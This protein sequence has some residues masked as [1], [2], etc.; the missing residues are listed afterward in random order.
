MESY[1]FILAWTS[2]VD[3]PFAR[4]LREKS[5][6][7]NISLYEITFSNF[8]ESLSRIEANK[9]SAQYSI[10]R[11]SIDYPPY[12]TL[13]E[14]LKKNGTR[15][16]NDPYHAA[17][18]GNKIILRDL[19]SKKELPLIE[20]HTI[21]AHGPFEKPPSIKPPFVIKSA[22]SADAESVEIGARNNA[23]IENF[24]ANNYF[25]GALIEPFITPKIINHA[26]AWFRSIFANG[27][28]IHHWWN[29]LNHVYRAFEGTTEEE[30]IARTLSSYAQ[31][32]FDIGKIDLFSFE[33]T[34]PSGEDELLIVDY[35]NQPIDL[36]TQT[37][38]PDGIP[39]STLEKVVG[40]LINVS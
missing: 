11:G 37:N 19:F 24:I 2:Y 29:P 18:V 35:L 8:E 33:T 1:D 14:M 9:L 20:A 26:P 10:D 3:E 16:I 39:E 28:I 34:I 25:D 23:D 4:M 5:R 32:I 7:K 38:T 30:G 15:I 31:K 13:L 6:E 21:T 36:N 40:A 27:A 12:L 17:K 22:H